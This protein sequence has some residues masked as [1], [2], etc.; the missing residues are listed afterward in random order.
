MAEDGV[1]RSPS[2][3]SFGAQAPSEVPSC[4]ARGREDFEFWT[5]RTLC[6]YIAAILQ[7]RGS[8]QLCSA[9]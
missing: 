7:R 2:T 1:E 8:S 3:L 6:I 9:S 4:L 5:K